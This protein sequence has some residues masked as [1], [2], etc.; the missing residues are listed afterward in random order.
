MVANVDTIEQNGET[1]Y[2][3]TFI[4]S[5]KQEYLSAKN[6]HTA[7]RLLGLQYNTLPDN[8]KEAVQNEINR[9][10]QVGILKT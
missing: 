2:K 3:N 9:K 1:L 6:V 8:V 10:K 4:E 5:C 7:L